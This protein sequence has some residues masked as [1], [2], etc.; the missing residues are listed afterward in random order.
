MFAQQILATIYG[1]YTASSKRF[2]FGVSAL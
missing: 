1:V 2:I